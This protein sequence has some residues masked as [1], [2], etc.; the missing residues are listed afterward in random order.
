MKFSHNWLN[1]YLTQTQT[2]TAQELA[3]TL[4]HA[5]LEVD[6]IEPVV[7][8]K[9]TG[10]LVG[11]ITK[12]EKHPD[13][14]KLNVCTVDIAAAEM[15][16]I[17]CG[18][19]N[20]YEGMK[21]PVAT[22]GAVLP[23]NFKIKKGQLRGIDSFGMMCS[24]EELGLLDSA[25]GLMDLPTNAPIGVDINTYLNLD[26]NAIEVDLTPNRAD[27]LSVYGMAREA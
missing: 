12:I 15:L 6:A 10:V 5:G 13:A 3:D 4:T 27:C 19:G 2:Q 18:A 9:V 21:A 17:V 16:T 26:D 20:I 11:Q 23:N 7:A 24:E 8:E 22:V 25:D 1:E 14:D